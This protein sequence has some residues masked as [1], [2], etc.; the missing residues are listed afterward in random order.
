MTFW[1]NP[2]TG[3]LTDGTPDSYNEL[4]SLWYYSPGLD[5]SGA[6]AGWSYTVES[7]GG[8]YS[9]Y[10]VVWR[11]IIGPGSAEPPNMRV[12]FGRPTL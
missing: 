2:E 3:R 1:L 12:G 10:F 11:D 9:S 7:L 8:G 6:A 5:S 4:D